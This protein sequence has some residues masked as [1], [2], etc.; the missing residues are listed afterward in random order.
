MLALSLSWFDLWRR[1]AALSWTHLDRL[2]AL[3]DP[4]HLRGW[5]LDDWRTAATDYMRSPAFLAMMRL[6]LTLLT[7]PTMIKATQMM[8]SPFALR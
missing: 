1:A 8:T 3:N 6:N 7:Q 5:F 4:R 2:T